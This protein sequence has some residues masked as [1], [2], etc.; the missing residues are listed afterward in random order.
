MTVCV[1]FND[2]TKS[3]YFNII[4]VTFKLGG[5]IELVRGKNRSI[6]LSNYTIKEIITEDDEVD[7]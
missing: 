7:S 4:D 3:T 2:N 1:K 5:V 6:L